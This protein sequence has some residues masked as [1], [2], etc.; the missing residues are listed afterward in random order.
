MNVPGF[1]Q[2]ITKNYFFDINKFADFQ[3]QILREQEKEL[4]IIVAH[5]YKVIIQV[6]K[7]MKKNVTKNIA[8]PSSNILCEE[9]VNFWDQIYMY[10]W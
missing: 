3:K 10:F 6:W 7:H 8:F 2:L 1:W 4:A 5:S 9:E